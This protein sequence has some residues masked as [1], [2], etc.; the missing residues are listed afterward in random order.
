MEGKCEQSDQK[1]TEPEVAGMIDL[2]V[3]MWGVPGE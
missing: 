3:G 2:Q 1:G